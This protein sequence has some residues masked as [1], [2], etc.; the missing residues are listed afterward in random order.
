[1]WLVLNALWQVFSLV[2]KHR[3][4]GGRRVEA[5]LEFGFHYYYLSE[6]DTMHIM[7]IQ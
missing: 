5:T 3:R 2:G 6:G 4:S 7:H 1:M